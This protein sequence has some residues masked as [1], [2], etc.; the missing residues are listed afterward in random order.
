MKLSELIEKLQALD[1]KGHGNLPVCIGFQNDNA[2]PHEFEK[3]ELVT[4]SSK[5]HIELGSV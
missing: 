2:M 4:E 5:S 1:A 3:I